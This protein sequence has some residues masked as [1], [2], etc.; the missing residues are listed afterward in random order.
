MFLCKDYFLAIIE[1]SER[2]LREEVGKQF[3]LKN[4]STGSLEQH[5]GNK[6]SQATIENGFKCWSFI[7]SQCDKATV[8]NVE[9][10]QSRAYLG[11]YL[12]INYPDLEIIV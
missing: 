6:V 7:S 8:K 3:T 5:L 10:Y 9:D 2:L 11:H 1:E 4:K 12:R